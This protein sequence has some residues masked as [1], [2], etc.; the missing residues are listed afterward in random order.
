MKRKEKKIEKNGGNAKN[1]KK[2]SPFTVH[3][4]RR[5]GEF[6]VQLF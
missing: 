6:I 4:K 2:K 5:G 3:S 1:R